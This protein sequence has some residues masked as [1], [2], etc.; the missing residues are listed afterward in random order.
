MPR[1]KRKIVAVH[2]DDSRNFKKN[3]LIGRVG[4]WNKPLKVWGKVGVPGYEYGTFRFSY[5][6][7]KASRE[8]SCYAIS[9]IPV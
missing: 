1:K 7:K 8:I 4:Y 3:T 5:P 6:N 2:P 9:T